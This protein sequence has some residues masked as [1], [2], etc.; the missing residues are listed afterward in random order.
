[1]L[2]VS[3]LL[4]YATKFLRG[5]L[6][7]KP[8]HINIE[9]GEE[10]GV[11][12]ELVDDARR[13][14]RL[15]VTDPSG[16][17]TIPSTCETMPGARAGTRSATPQSEGGKEGGGETSAESRK[18]RNHKYKVLFGLAFPFALQSPDTT[19]IASAL[20]FIAADFGQV[21]QLNWIVSVFNLTAASFLPFWAC[22]W[23]TPYAGQLAV[24][25]CY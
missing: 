25:L 2:L 1:M 22:C 11:A 20:P 17:N 6:G 18:R 7:A 12:Y 23:R 4:E 9:D 14:P 19:I 5:P 24:V 13:D 10:P 15:T 16:V 21:Q 8:R 3:L